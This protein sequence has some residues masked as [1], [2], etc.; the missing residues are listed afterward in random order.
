MPNRKASARWTGPLS[1]GQGTMRLGS[2]AYE[3]PFSF[4]TRRGDEPGTNPEELIGAAL[5]G[6]FSM[7]LSGAL[8]KAGVTAPV[9]DTE[10]TVTFEQSGGGWGISRIA[11][12]T[13]VKAAGLDE[14]RFQA[15]A[16]ETKQQ[17]PVSRALAA[18]PI[19]L[20]ATLLA[21]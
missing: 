2:G 21:E 4:Q 9:V 15:I 16:A 17:C 14:A 3:G 12:V 8:G 6:C 20:E 11:L 7:A 5:A 1:E 18:T 19:D 13:R 10:A